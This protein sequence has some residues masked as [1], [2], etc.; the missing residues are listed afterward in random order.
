MARDERPSL[1]FG[2]LETRRLII[3]LVLSLLVHLIGWGGYEYGKK[4][5]FWDRLHALL[6]RY[7]PPPK[8]N[9]AL[10]AKKKEQEQQQP[11][12]FVEVSQPDEAPTKETI[13]YSSQN[14]RAAN[15][16]ASKDVNQPKIDGKQEEIVK[17][18]DV[19]KVSKLHPSPTQPPS[20]PT[21]KKEEQQQQS[22][23]QNIGDQKLA[24]VEKT[25][26]PDESPQPKP[27]PRTL[28]EARAQQHQPLP[29]VK[30]RQ[31]GGTSRMRIVP[32]FDTKA[33]AFGDYDAKLIAAVSQYWYD[34]LDRNHFAYDR[35]GRVV[36]SFDLHYDGTVDSVEIID[37]NVG[38]LLGSF[39]QEAIDQTAPYEKWPNDMLHEIG[40][41][42]RTVKFTFFY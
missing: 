19:P 5:G 34:E 9:P 4:T 8:H 16:E 15:P 2:R 29:G 30:M 36:V 28:N 3:A 14:S 20:P 32:S 24:K 35:S 21:Q 10:E 27:R 31:D 22:S 12:I 7:M 1:R 11:T 6:V 17:T 26:T 40:S 23:S 39:C 42:K 33:T 18:E 25:E 37:N 13:Y 38:T 41:T